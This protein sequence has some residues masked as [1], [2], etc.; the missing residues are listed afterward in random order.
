MR[1]TALEILKQ[2]EDKGYSA[3][4]VGGYPRNLYLNLP[5][6][7]ID[8]CTSATPRDLKE[9]FQD[10]SLPTEQYGSVV[11]VRNKIRFEITTFRKEIKYKDKRHPLKIKYIDNLI[12]DLNRRDFTI[13][14]LCIDSKG[15]T[16]DFLNAKADIDCRIIRTVG[17][18]KNKIKEDSL[19]ILRA[20]RFATTLGFELDND[21]K[22]YI[23]KYGSSL[24]KLSYFRKQDELNKIFSSPSALIGIKLIADL[25]LDKYLEL[26]NIHQVKMTSS[27]LGIWAQLGSLDKYKFSNHEK[28]T[29]EAI[30]YLKDNDILDNK[31]LYKFGLY[32]STIAG[33]IQGIERSVITKK[34]NELYIKNK[35]DIILKPTDI[36]QLLNKKPGP[37]LK[38]I[39]SDLENKIVNKELKNEIVELTN[40]VENNYNKKTHTL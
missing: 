36:C 26:S 30:N 9:I 11:L 6:T 17:N 23:K 22:H 14:T 29:I 33:E 39:I 7:D 20:I 27:S 16:I 21:L 18:P 37:F 13:N 25:R 12:Q 31:N 32:I 5:S 28:E 19:R 3:Y 40:Y 2:I 8:I 35:K 15:N 38:D 10:I 24:K 4:I 1:E 34:Y